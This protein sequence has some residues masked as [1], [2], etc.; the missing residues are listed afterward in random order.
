[1]PKRLCTQV[2]GRFCGAA[3]Q[4]YPRGPADCQSA[5]R[6]AGCQPA[7]HHTSVS[8]YMSRTHL[9]VHGEAR[10]GGMTRAGG[11]EIPRVTSVGRDCEPDCD[12][13]TL[14]SRSITVRITT[15]G[16][17]EEHT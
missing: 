6:R 17:S 9:R 16:R 1:M 10:N 7:P 12:G 5:N 2:R 11:G 13:N 4:G 14:T 15:K 8:T 3:W